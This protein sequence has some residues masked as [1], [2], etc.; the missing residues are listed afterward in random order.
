[1]VG[2]LILI[3]SHSYSPLFQYFFHGCFKRRECQP[4][5][6][7]WGHGGRAGDLV[8]LKHQ[9]PGG[10]ASGPAVPVD[11]NGNVQ[12]S[13]SLDPGYNW[14]WLEHNSAGDT[15]ELMRRLVFY[16]ENGD[17]LGDE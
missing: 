17:T 10:T 9:V 6:D 4:Q 16:V 14:V 13:Q 7:V 8:D 12:S 15:H 1:M 5:I 3:A 2:F 11:A